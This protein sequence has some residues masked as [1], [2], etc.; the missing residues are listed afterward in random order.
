MDNGFEVAIHLPDISGAFDKVDSHLMACRLWE[1][2]LSHSMLSLLMHFFACRQ[3]VV[4]V[5][6]SET[7]QHTKPDFPENGARPTL[8]EC[9]P[10]N[11]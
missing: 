2:G 3:A 5:Q 8:V 4:V 6:G 10:S 9:F 7:F 11:D 1:I